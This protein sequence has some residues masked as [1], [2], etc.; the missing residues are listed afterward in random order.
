MVTGK[1]LKVIEGFHH[2]TEI[3]ITGMTAKCAGSG[4]GPTVSETLDTYG[5]W[6]IKEYIKRIKETLSS[7]VVCRPIYELCTGEYRMAGISKFMRWWEQD[8]GREVE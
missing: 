8:V 4:S 6:P 1:M 7:Q 5:L 2:R 3:R